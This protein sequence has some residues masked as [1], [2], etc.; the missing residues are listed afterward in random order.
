MV[1]SLW[2]L[3]LTC[4]MSSLF[5]SFCV[6]PVCFPIFQAFI[7]F[8][9]PAFWHFS[10][11]PFYVLCWTWSCHWKLRPCRVEN[12]VDLFLWRGC[13]T[14]F[15]ALCFWSSFIYSV[16]LLCQSSTFLIFSLLF[17]ISG[18]IGFYMFSDLGRF[19]QLYLSVFSLKKK[20][21]LI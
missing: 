7:F 6:T 10:V 19:Y 17:Q 5:E 3:S 4:S 9:S 13:K 21:V 20:S 16:N 12:F 11:T 2:V 8:L 18:L 15:Y 1:P 14:C